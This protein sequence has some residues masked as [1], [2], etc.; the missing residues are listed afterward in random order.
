MV[1]PTGSLNNKLVAEGVDELG[2]VAGACVVM[3][4]LPIVIEAAGVHLPIERHKDRVVQPTSSLNHLF[5]G[6]T[7]DYLGGN[8]MTGVL[9]AELPIVV[10]AYA[11][12]HCAR[13]AILVLVLVLSNDHRVVVA[14]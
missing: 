11:V 6:E 10:P 14:A 7:F 13:D 1:V 4:E 3:A 12:H 8:F 2:R 9:L 5:G